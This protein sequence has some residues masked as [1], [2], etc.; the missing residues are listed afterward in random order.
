MENGWKWDAVKLVQVAESLHHSFS[1][2]VSI[3]TMW[4]LH[5]IPL[6]ASVPHWPLLVALVCRGVTESGG[7]CRNVENHV[8]YCRCTPGDQHRLGGPKD[9]FQYCMIHWLWKRAGKC[10]LNVLLMCLAKLLIFHIVNSMH[11]FF[12][13][14]WYWR[15]W[16]DKD[17]MAGDEDAECS[18]LCRGRT[19]GYGCFHA[20]ALVDSVPIVE[21]RNLFLD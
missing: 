10:D 12:A 1:D 13:L 20:L 3:L 5:E 6:H 15:I 21:C 4:N 17:V 16:G 18:V 14:N 8:N 19:A 11:F 9:L 7:S 2:L